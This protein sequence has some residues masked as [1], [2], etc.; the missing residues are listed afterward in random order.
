MRKT[1][2]ELSLAVASYRDETQSVG[3]VHNVTSTRVTEFDFLSEN[4]DSGCKLAL[5]QFD[6]YLSAIS[7]TLRPNRD[8]SM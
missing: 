7:I 4:L 8:I 6:F 3:N 1:L 2:L 5:T